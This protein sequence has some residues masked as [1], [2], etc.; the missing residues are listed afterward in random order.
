M[1]IFGQNQGPGRRHRQAKK[2]QSEG[3]GAPNGL[4]HPWA[5]EQV[6]WLASGCSSFPSSSSFPSLS[7]FP[8]PWVGR[9]GG[10][11]RPTWLGRLAGPAAGMPAGWLAD[12]G[13]LTLSKK[14][15]RFR[16]PRICGKRTVNGLPLI[17]F[18]GLGGS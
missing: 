5:R 15:L 12:R 1:K 4:S 16:K 14:I 18:W 7:S 11:A 10:V 9:R 2:Y 13:T 17:I 3:V 6:G 8:L